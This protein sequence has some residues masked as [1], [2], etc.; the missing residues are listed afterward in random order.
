MD[1]PIPQRPLIAESLDVLYE[2]VE[3]DVSGDYDKFLELIQ[4]LCDTGYLELLQCADDM[5][6][7]KARTGTKW[8]D[9]VVLSDHIKKKILLQMIENPKCF[10]VL[11]NTQRGKLRIIG[12]EI[13]SWITLPY[14]RVVSYLVV[15]NDR[16]LSDQSTNGL[17][18]C[19]PLKEGHES[20]SDPLEKYNVRIFQLSSTNKTSLDEIITYI[21]AY[22]FNSNY[23]M[24]LIVLLA[25]NK[26]IEKLIRILD[27]I[28]HH[29]CAQLRA[30]G[31]WDEADQTYPQFREKNF[32]VNGRS[33]NFRQLLDHSSERIIRN[34]FVT[35]TEGVL[36]DEEYEECANAYHYTVDMDPVD[37]E[38]YIS[39]HHAECVK[40]TILVRPRESNNVIASRVLNDNWDAHFNVPLRLRDGT[41]Y[42]HKVIINADSTAV[43]MTKF[44]KSLSAKAHVITFNMLGVK[45][46]NTMFPDG[47][48]YSARKQ[49][50]NRLLFYIYKMNN[51][52]DKPLIIIGRRK[53]DRGLGFHY[54]PRVRGPFTLA[55]DGIDGTLRTDGREGLIWTDMC[56]GNKIEHIA[57]SVQK[58]GR[59]AGII[60]QCPQYP[61]EFHYWVEEST[62]RNIERHYKKVDAVNILTGSNS[63][64]QALTRAEAGIPVIRHNHSVD[65]STFRV[66]RGTTATETLDLMKR[67]ITDVFHKSYRTPQRDEY[68]KYK[69]SVNNES[70]VVDLLEAVKKVPGAYGVHH[71]DRVYRR[72]L[73]CYRDMADNN[74]LCCVIPLIDP[75]YTVAMKEILDAEFR[76]H[77]VSVPNDGDIL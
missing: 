70:H 25:N 31:A 59:G 39:Y 41:P 77:F 11:F 55:V 58:A 15:S 8:S 2:S 61:I 27:H 37:Q 19:F 60:R 42:Y 1:V 52:D 76:T 7:Y 9:I 24:P 51:L 14:Q 71:G 57:T 29:S 26:Q 47:K 66:L 20:I 23:P 43:E 48:R 46:F 65:E 45:L 44:A 64:F 4:G 35:A 28:I 75:A 53:I 30:G 6:M 16:T 68:G 17:F 74:S 40:H 69:T 73:P 12:Q 32:T 33:V 49:N 72:F 67:I 21:D 63:M 10:F 13:A 56:M 38:N 36:M 3:E 50:L 34:G 54:A 18:S 5:F 22:A 62:S